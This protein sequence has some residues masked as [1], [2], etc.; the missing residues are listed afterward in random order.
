MKLIQNINTIVLGDFICLVH[1]S[2]YTDRINAVNIGRVS[3]I[4]NQEAEVSMVLSPWVAYQLTEQNTMHVVNLGAQ[5]NRNTMCLPD[6][7]SNFICFSCDDHIV[8][9]HILLNTI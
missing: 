3:K 6:I 8:E 1:R 5:N 7:S 9:E 2:G 4:T